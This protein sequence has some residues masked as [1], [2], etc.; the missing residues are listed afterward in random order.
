MFIY[1]IKCRRWRPEF[2]FFFTFNNHKSFLEVH[3]AKLF[4]PSNFP[5]RARKIQHNTNLSRS[6]WNN[7]HITQLSIK[8]Q[9]NSETDI[10]SFFFVFSLDSLFL[11]TCFQSRSMMKRLFCLR[12]KQIHLTVTTQ[13]KGNTNNSNNLSLFFFFDWNVY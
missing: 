9:R 2:K 1:L 5:F 10:L 4:R 13:W 8:F 12:R 3:E 11:F 7:K 6:P